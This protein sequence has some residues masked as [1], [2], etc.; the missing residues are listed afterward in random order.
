M[1]AVFLR[2][3][4][5]FIYDLLEGIKERAHCPSAGRGG[6]WSTVV[7]KKRNKAAKKHRYTPKKVP[8]LK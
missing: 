6:K 1:L 4:G 3:F 8:S 2:F 5:Y 7:H